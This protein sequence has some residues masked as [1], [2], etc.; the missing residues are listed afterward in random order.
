[1]N[2]QPKH[3]RFRAYQLVSKGASFS[4]WDGTNFTLGE[5]RFNDE[6][7]ASIYHELGVCGKTKIDTLYISSWE[8]D[9]CNPEELIQILTLFKPSQIYLP[10]Y[11]PSPE[12]ESQIISKRLIDQYIGPPVPLKVNG[13][14]LPV[15]TPWAY[16]DSFCLQ[17]QYEKSNDNSLVVLFHSG[18]IGVLSVGDIESG[19]ISSRFLT[20]PMLQEEVDIFLLS[21]HGSSIDFNT[22]EF[23]KAL[24]PHVCLALVDRENQYGH[25]DPIVRQRA[26][27]HSFYFSTKDGDVIIETNAG[28]ANHSTFTVYN[29]ISNGQQLQTMKSF[30]SKRGKRNKTHVWSGL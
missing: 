27:D 29:Y 9:H 8:I 22:V 19:E 28:F 10:W 17:D 23:I 12:V 18:N 14:G 15:A 6:N 3:T 4:Y 24:N 25:P 11:L 21:H 20:Y 2:F 7:K 5:A 30:E 13:H 1:M 26:N 16:A